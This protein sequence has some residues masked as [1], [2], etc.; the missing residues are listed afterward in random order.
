LWM[1]CTHSFEELNTFL[2]NTGLVELETVDVSVGLTSM[3][4]KGRGRGLHT[5]EEQQANKWLLG[6]SMRPPKGV[7]RVSKMLRDLE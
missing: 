2:V 3:K 5:L 6:R 7:Q 1:E 4:H